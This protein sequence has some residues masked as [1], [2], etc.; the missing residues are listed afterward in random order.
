MAITGQFGDF[1][2]GFIGTLF[3]LAGALLLFLNLKE[4]RSSFY[5]ER[6]EGKFFEMIQLHRDNVSEMELPVG[7]ND[8]YK[9]RKVIHA[10]VAQFE[11]L[12]AD[13]STFYD[14]KFPNDIYRPEYLEALAKNETINTRGISLELYA[15]IDITYLIVFFGLSRNGYETLNRFLDEHYQSSFYLPLLK[16][17]KLKPIKDSIH[18][19][20]WEYINEQFGTDFKVRAAIQMFHDRENNVTLPNDV[21]GWAADEDLMYKAAYYNDRYNKFY[22][23]HQFRLGH[24]FRHIFQT[25]TFIDGQTGLSYDQKYEHVKFFRGQLSTYEQTL[26]FLNSLSTLGR[27]V[28][29]EKRNVRGK[30]IKIKRQLVTKYN[31]IKNIPSDEI[32]TGLRIS[33]FY[34]D[35]AYEAIFNSGVKERRKELREK[36]WESL[37]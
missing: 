32:I 34:P 19:K 22:G 8:T 37:D 25:I 2:G 18:F 28:E 10:I 3:N 1:I 20:K 31:L 7:V 5:Q 26:Y 27:I 4:Q 30:G 15:R 16:F 29:F 35:I 13:T 24:Y 33:S 17:A 11:R 12:Y 23:G 21:A 9:G 36:Y 14:G 6:L